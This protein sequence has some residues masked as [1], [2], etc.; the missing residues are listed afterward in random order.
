MYPYRPLY[1]LVSLIYAAQNYSTILYGVPRAICVP[2]HRPAF[3]TG[4]PAGAVH[5]A[6]WRLPPGTGDVPEQRRAHGLSEPSP[7]VGRRRPAA[8]LLVSR[9]G[10]IRGERHGD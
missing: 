10:R 4:A 3:P 7:R 5:T 6:R 8:A 9:P 1:A 2:C